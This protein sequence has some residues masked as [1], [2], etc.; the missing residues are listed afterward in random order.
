MNRIAQKKIVCGVVC[1][2]NISI[3]E[4]VNFE[5]NVRKHMCKLLK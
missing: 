4:S 1:V 3:K 5:A 2:C